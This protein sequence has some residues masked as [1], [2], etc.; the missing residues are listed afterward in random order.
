MSFIEYFLSNIL[1]NIL[2]VLYYANDFIRLES[3][4]FV[5]YESYNFPR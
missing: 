5:N 2:Y 4:N 1:K 3:G